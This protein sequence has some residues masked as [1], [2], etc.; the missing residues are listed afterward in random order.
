MSVRSVV[1][2]FHRQ[3]ILA[4][5]VASIAAS[6]GTASLARADLLTFASF[7]T[8]QG[9]APIMGFDSS[10]D[11]YS[12]GSNGAAGAASVLFYFTNPTVYSGQQT[13]D[14]GIPALL[15]ISGV[16]SGPA[17]VL[18]VAFQPAYVVQPI[19]NLTFTFTA[20]TPVAG[21]PVLLS[22]TASTGVIEGA[23]NDVTG[24]ID[25]STL[26]S[27]AIN[28]SSNV[29][30]FSGATTEQYNFVINPINPGLYTDDTD[31]LLPFTADATGSF[32]VV[33]GTVPEPASLGLLG[34]GALLLLRRRRS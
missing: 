12:I 3:A 22:T 20:V 2:S 8:D 16:A 10:G 17:T 25:G 1:R 19:S 23:Y 6:L 33:A 4:G 29:L 21:E 13:A 5:V 18:Y 7:Q 27:D 26:S 34:T 9:T 32:D 11:V 28:F 15:T 31:D 30:N 24:N 14:G